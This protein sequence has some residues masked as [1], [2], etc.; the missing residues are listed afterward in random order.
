MSLCQNRA[1]PDIP[2]SGV[3]LWGEA[4]RVDWMATGSRMVGSSGTHR[5]P[6]SFL[7][8][9]A[10]GSQDSAIRSGQSTTSIPQTHGFPTQSAYSTCGEGSQNLTMMQRWNT[11]ISTLRYGEKDPCGRISRLSLVPPQARKWMTLDG[12]R[13]QVSLE[14]QR[15]SCMTYPHIDP[16][17]SWSIWPFTNTLCDSWILPERVQP[18]HGQPM[19][20]TAKLC[21]KLRTLLR[22][23]GA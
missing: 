10:Y 18:A 8:I 17:G 20:A 2:G 12:G 21:R 13:R 23:I 14:R 1:A 9:A 7:S 4:W 6:P 11:A 22:G 16:T 15:G 19:S 5:R 3:L